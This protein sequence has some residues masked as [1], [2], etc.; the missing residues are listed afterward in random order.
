MS[1]L[2]KILPGILQKHCCI[3][4]ERNTEIQL[5]NENT[6]VLIHGVKH[7]KHAPSNSMISTICNSL[8]TEAVHADMQQDLDNTQAWADKWQ[9]TLTPHNFQAMT[10]SKKKASNHLPLT[11]NAI[12]IAE[13]L[14]INI[15]IDW[16]LNLTSH[17][18]T[19][20]TRAD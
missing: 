7:Y 5:M 19:V 15:T 16:K 4:P 20:A 2:K 17:I 10:I 11:F 12:T 13:Y 1:A 9:I 18:N 6:E 14:T 8:D 3:L